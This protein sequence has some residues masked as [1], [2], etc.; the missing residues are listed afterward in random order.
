MSY[1]N[2]DFDFKFAKIFDFSCISHILSIRTDPLHVFSV[3][4][5]IHSAYYQYE[6]Q[7]C[8]RR[9]TSFHE[10]SMYVCMYRFSPR[11]PSI[12]TDSFRVL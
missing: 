5:Q 12:R 11:I 10:F 9:F 8:V 7:N 1:N 3:Y 4:K 2:F 6:Q